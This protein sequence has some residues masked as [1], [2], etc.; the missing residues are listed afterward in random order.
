MINKAGH[1]GEVEWY[2]RPGLLP[3]VED[4]CAVG[5]MESQHRSSTLKGLL[6]LGSVLEGQGLRVPSPEEKGQA[7]STIPDLPQPAVQMPV[8]ASSEALPLPHWLGP[9][10]PL[11][12]CP[13]QLA[14]PSSGQP[15]LMDRQQD[16]PQ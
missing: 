4:Q 3:R 1:Q 2:G 15:L 14:W 11:Q 10:I 9:G 7:D 12:S 6:A 8:E 13:A 5:H 16:Y